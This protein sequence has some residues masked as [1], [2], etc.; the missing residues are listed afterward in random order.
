M[1]TRLAESHAIPLFF[2]F[3]NVDAAVAKNIEV[4]IRVLNLPS[5][6]QRAGTIAE[7]GPFVLEQVDYFFPVDQGRLKL[8][9]ER[10]SLPDRGN[11][12]ELIAY[13]RTDQS[14]ARTSDYLI[15][16]TQEPDQMRQTLGKVLGTG[17]VV[18]KR[19]ELYLHGRTRI[20][21]DEVEGLGDFVEIE[22][23]MKDG[24]DNEAGHR[25]LDEIARQ[26]GLDMS[27]VESLAYADLL[28][29]Q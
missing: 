1:T 12:A 8:R 25:E 3:R 27:G 24:E 20:H 6:R 21:L 26:L 14:E 19:R 5:I 22:V 9:V 2:W 28:A 23:V 17:P 16:P 10:S 18:R 4:K 7:R 15:C 13:H 11:H 29:A